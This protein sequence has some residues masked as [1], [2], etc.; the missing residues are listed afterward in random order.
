M[1][2]AGLNV[3]VGT[4][5]VAGSDALSVLEELR[6]IWASEPDVPAATI[7][8]MGTLGGAVGMGCEDRYGSLRSGVAADFVA[9]PIDPAGHGDPVVNLLESDRTVTGVWMAGHHVGS[10]T[11]EESA[12]KRR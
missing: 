7:L 9:V 1:L 5:S 8:E 6:F 10:A 12:S 11:D 4:D 3:C 2:A